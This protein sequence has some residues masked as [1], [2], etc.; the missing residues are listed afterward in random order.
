MSNGAVQG[1]FVYGFDDGILTCLDLT[2]GKRMWRG[3]SY[4]FGQLLLVDNTLLIQAESGDVALVDAAPGAFHESAHFSAIEGKTWN[5][6]VLSG[7]HL[8]VR[9]DHEAACYELP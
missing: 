7:H 3:D 5:N 2:T 9:N 1:N 6:P 4:G 8:L